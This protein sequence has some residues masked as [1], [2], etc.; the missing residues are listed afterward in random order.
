[1][2]VNLASKFNALTT[3]LIV[4]TALAAAGLILHRVQSGY[5][6][7]L[8]DYGAEL[9]GLVAGLSEFGIYA[10]NRDEL[11]QIA[12]HLGGQGDVAYLAIYDK[13]GQLLLER[14]Y[15]NAPI[16]HTGAPPSGEIAAQRTVELPD[17]ATALE[18]TQPVTAAGVGDADSDLMLGLTATPR[19]ELVGYVRL[20]LS[21]QRLQ[22]QLHGAWL[23][24]AGVTLA[25]VLVGIALTLFLTRRIT[26]PVR[27][28]MRATHDIAE[29]RLDQH[30]TVNSRDEM[31]SLAESFN[32]MTG[33]LR[34][35]RDQ[36]EDY[37]RNLERK[38]EERTRELQKAK[39]SA[40]QANTAKSQFLANM[41]HEL[42]TPLNAIIGYSELLEEDCEPQ[43]VPHFAADLRKVQAAGR[44]LLMLINDVLDLSKIEAGRMDLYLED[45]VVAHVVQDVV[46]TVEL[47]LAKNRNTLDVQCPPEAGAIRADVTKVR[48][49]LFNLLSNASKF[50][51]QGRVAL[52][53]TREQG[54]GGERVCFEVSDSG[55][56]MTPEQLARLFTPFTQ[57]DSSTTRK[58]G[59]TGLGLCITKRFSEMM[60]GNIEVESTPGNG[61]RF[62]VRLPVAVP[63]IATPL[64]PET[65]PAADPLRV[66]LAENADP[67]RRKHLSQV[68]VIDDDTSMHEIIQR[69]L[70]KEGFAHIMARDGAEG[71]RLAKGIKPDL[72]TLDVM[73]PGMDGWT[74]LK[75]LK[76]DPETAN[77]P[78]VMLTLLGEKSLGFALGADDYVLKPLDWDTLG[79]VIKRCVRTN[80]PVLAS[81]G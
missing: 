58:Y 11:A 74:V 71:L 77:I 64:K 39:E 80:A 46:A 60:G 21:H 69:H 53:V 48:Q 35:Y 51:R 55:I 25:V 65:P 57:A 79:A 32:R 49:I 17:G 42:R 37:Q 66:R 36:V 75:A 22:A 44:H 13:V 34:R 8:S 19:P 72:I 14:G 33:Q 1:M 81:S 5:R 59:G 41:S 2:R 30:V 24:T 7:Q 62:R 29:G 20:L 40:E 43:G 47:L 31:H 61:S 28:L 73:M 23:V 56:G 70:A 67:E 52:R 9:A 54:T 38:V 12:D 50:T 26:L 3:T 10:G 78:V 76:Q 15:R 45:M 63:E 18:I 4:L 68:L 16:Q 6:Q 27:E